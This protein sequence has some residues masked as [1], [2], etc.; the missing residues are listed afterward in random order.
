LT[1]VLNNALKYSPGGS[2]V[3]CEV[4]DRQS[5]WRLSIRDQGPGIPIEQQTQLFR[6][7]QRLHGESHPDV[8]GIGLGLLLVSTTLQR[9]GGTVEI[10]SARGSGCTVILLLP[11]PTAAALQSIAH[12][13]SLEEP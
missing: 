1:N 12:A 11:K 2:E 5:H 3:L 13:N 4:A 9:H 6:P 7:F 8:P 10:E